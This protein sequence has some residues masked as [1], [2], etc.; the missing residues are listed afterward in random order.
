MALEQ[1][2]E[3]HPKLLDRF[4]LIN[5]RSVRD[6]FL[7]RYQTVAPREASTVSEAASK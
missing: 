7:E 3:T 5:G 4:P 1:L 6:D 2:R